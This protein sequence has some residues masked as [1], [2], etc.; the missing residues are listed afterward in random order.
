[1][2]CAQNQACSPVYLYGPPAKNNFHIFKWLG[3]EDY[4]VTHEK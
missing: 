4:F 2:A 1:M 3:E